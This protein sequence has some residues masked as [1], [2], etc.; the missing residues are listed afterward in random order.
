MTA[1][2]KGQLVKVIQI[3][4]HRAVIVYQGMLKRV[5]PGDLLDLSLITG[6]AASLALLA[7]MVAR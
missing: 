1:R 4:A 7:W 3:E 6:L 5:N 2:Y